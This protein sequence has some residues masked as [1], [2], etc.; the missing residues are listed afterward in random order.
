M[1]SPA[2]ILAVEPQYNA[3]V[4]ELFDQPRNIASDQ[5]ELALRG[6]GGSVPSGVW[7]EF[8]LELAQQI[9]QKAQ[10]RAFGCPHTIALASWLT[11]QL[12]GQELTQDYSLDKEEITNVLELPVEKMRSVLVAEDALRACVKNLAAQ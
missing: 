9:I 6:E 2:S 3:L 7:I 8:Q 4:T 1:R 12:V 11:E 10:F 5:N